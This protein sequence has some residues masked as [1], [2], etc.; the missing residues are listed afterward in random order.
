MSKEN[1]SSQHCA[2]CLP[3][4]QPTGFVELNASQ[5]A[6]AHA[7]R[8]PRSANPG[9]ALLLACADARHF[10]HDEALAI[11]DAWRP[12]FK[13]V[14]LPANDPIFEHSFW[15]VPPTSKA[16]GATEDAEDF[17]AEPF[18][19]TERKELAARN[20]TQE[21]ELPEQEDS[22]A[23]LDLARKH[24]HLTSG[25]REALAEGIY[26]YGTYLARMKLVLREGCL[27]EDAA[28]GFAAHAVR[29]MDRGKY[30]DKGTFRGWLSSVWAKYHWQAITQKATLQR[31]TEKGLQYRRGEEGERPEA[32]RV[33]ADVIESYEPPRE[34]DA[35]SDASVT[36]SLLEQ[37]LDLYPKLPPF[38]RRVLDG[39]LAGK[40]TEQIAQQESFSAKTIQAAWQRIQAKAQAVTNA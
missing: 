14:K 25:E 15:Q 40:R 16:S 19:D 18:E 26:R 35:D 7:Y 24:P 30:Q 28:N 34:A 22:L 21:A 17:F 36:Q 1:L 39:R 5:L 12:S 38:E 4:S 27:V 33:F 11:R 37:L 3:H 6:V 20:D 13:V 2:Q 23:Y 31:N 8:K 9:E 32:G 10:Y 29:L